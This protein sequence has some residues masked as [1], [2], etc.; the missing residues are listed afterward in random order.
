MH[1]KSLKNTGQPS[2]DTETSEMLFD[3][4]PWTS[5]A[6]GIPVSPFQLPDSAKEKKTNGISG[7]KCID[8]FVSY[9]Q[10]TSSWRTSQATFN[11]G[12]DVFS[13]TWPKAGMMRN[14]RC[15]LRDSLEPDTYDD[16][17]L[18]WRTPD[19]NAGRGPSSK[20]RMEWKLKNK[21]PIS[22]NDQVR[23]WPTP[24]ANCSTGAGK[25]GT[26]GKNLQTMVQQFPTP[27]AQD[28]KRSGPNSSQQGLSSIGN[29]TI[30]Q[31][32]P[33]WVEWLMGFEIGWTDLNASATPSSR[34]SQK[35]S[36][37]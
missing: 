22:L 7:P 36:G 12:S 25:H 21:M 11:W 13:E 18:L 5:S 10:D 14:G 8:S 2:N 17:F 1:Q 24:H 32:N 28:F 15:Y 9:D 33:T 30:G 31:L 6:E 29:R 27:T 19:A 4:I 16:E 26:G 23:H 34:R 3:L 37:E 20:E 35:K